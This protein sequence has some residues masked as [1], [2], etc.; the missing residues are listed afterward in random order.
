M[1]S[2]QRFKYVLLL[3]CCLPLFI[4]GAQQP[5][6]WHN[7][8]ACAMTGK[9]II[10]HAA[11]PSMHSMLQ[12]CICQSLAFI[13]QN[14]KKVGIIASVGF[15][16]CAACWAGIKGIARY[17]AA[18]VEALQGQLQ[19]EKDALIGFRGQVQQEQKRVS[20]YVK[21]LRSRIRV[22]RRRDQTKL[23]TLRNSLDRV[24]Y[25]Q[26]RLRCEAEGSLQTI[27][28]FEEAR[29]EWHEIIEERDLR[30][31]FLSAKIARLKMKKR[32]EQG[33]VK[34]SE[35]CSLLGF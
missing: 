31:D 34:R 30:I 1:R 28:E 3:E 32:D 25:E 9:R 12:C 17:K 29:K 22:I 4:C 6:G 7:I 33:S 18:E 11:C 27:L 21:S 24:L 19:A 15:L 8:Y 10:L 23:K 14:S 20:L 35:S 5:S 26:A 16:L 13:Q 2:M